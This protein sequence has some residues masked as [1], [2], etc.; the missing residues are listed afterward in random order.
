MSVVFGPVP[1]RRLGRSLGINNIYPKVCS[2]SCIYCQA[3]LT[4][5]LSTELK[6]FY[7][8]MMIYNEVR[9][10]LDEIRKNDERIDYL[11]FVPDGEPLL[12][13]SLE[14]TIN[15]LQEFGIKI[16][17]FTN[18]S[19]LWKKKVRSVLKSA[20][21][22]SVKIDAVDNL[23][24]KKINRPHNSLQIENI[25]EGILAFNEEYEG[26]LVTETMLVGGVNDNED[27]LIKTAHCIVKI[28]PET[29]YLTIP[30][31]PAPL[32]GIHSPEAKKTESSF[33]IFKSVYPSTE[34]LN[35]YEGDEFSAC[36]D[37]EDN[38]LSILAV[39]PMRIDAAE[40]YIS[41]SDSD[42]HLI[43]KLVNEGKIKICSYEENEFLIKISD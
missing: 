14:N 11:S 34:L 17:V 33:R 10:R 29:A 42:S 9:R 21:Y 41:N 22:V 28:K 5:E 1:S 16:A 30:T 35:Y 12:D 7:S 27:D 39:H 15:L 40:K 19:L 18:A 43:Q 20:D 31:R 38:L 4:S 13:C 26:K 25:L 32:K 3:G 8:P 2:Y 36:P 24:W 6:N 23:T 37:T